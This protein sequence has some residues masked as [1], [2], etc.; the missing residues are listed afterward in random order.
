[1]CLVCHGT[2][3]VYEDFNFTTEIVFN[4]A[5]A[6][7]SCEEDDVGRMKQQPVYLYMERHGKTFIDKSVKSLFEGVTDLEETSI[8]TEHADNKLKLSEN[9][10]N[11]GHRDEES[12]GGYQASEKEDCSVRLRLTPSQ[13]FLTSS[14]WRNDEVNMLQGF[15]TKFAFIITDLSRSCTLVRDAAFSS[16]K[17]ESC[18]VH[19]GDGFTFSIHGDKTTSSALGRGGEQLGAGG[20]KNLLAV[21]FDIWYNPDVGDLIEDHIT[22]YSNGKEELTFGESSQLHPPQ[23][24]RLADGKIHNARIVYYPSLRQEYFQYFKLTSHATSFIKDKEEGYR[25]GTLV[26]WVDDM[27][28]PVIALPINLAVLLD[29]DHAVVGFTAATGKSWASHDILSWHFCETAEDPWCL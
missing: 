22:V 25:V 7:S 4:G 23:A 28:T 15:S 19:G 11:L 21:E 17:Y 10:A 29:V 5:A 2:G 9:S 1:M 24:H 27:D 18:V 26:I 14:V 3:F 16:K 8:E 13:P 12:W 6:T 20:L